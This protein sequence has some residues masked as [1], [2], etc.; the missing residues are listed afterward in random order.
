MMQEQDLEAD[1][2]SIPSQPTIA[3]EYAPPTTRAGSA[4]ALF[5]DS[6]D[7][8]GAEDAMMEVEMTSHSTNPN[9][10]PHANPPV[11]AIPQ[12]VVDWST[13]PEIDPD[14]IDSIQLGRTPRESSV[15]LESS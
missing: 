8:E 14:E 7:E 15:S 12:A 3:P 6:S 1:P 4:K 2:F 11:P 5:F 9:P 10:E 13:V